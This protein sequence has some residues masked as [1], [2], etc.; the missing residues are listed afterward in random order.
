MSKLL[1]VDDEQDI[2]TSLKTFF[3]EQVPHLGV[4]TASSGSDGLKLLRDGRADLIICDYR[5]PGMDGV[6]FLKR[7][8]RM[9]PD[10][11]RLMITAFPEAGLAARVVREAGVS[12]MIAKPFDLGALVRTV[13]A[14]LE[15]SSRVGRPVTVR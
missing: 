3:E 8:Q 2:L 11:P 9:A 4:L 15:E 10:V 1:I 5:M 12:L 13:R 14:M 6:E 7:A